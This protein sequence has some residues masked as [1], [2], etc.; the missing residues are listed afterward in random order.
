MMCA[1]KL[2]QTDGGIFSHKYQN[3][4]DF[5]REVPKRG[6]RMPEKGIQSGTN[7][8]RVKPSSFLRLFLLIIKIYV[9]T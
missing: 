7:F 4:Y 2:E 9:Q 8:P 1:A 3:V 6:T 5:E